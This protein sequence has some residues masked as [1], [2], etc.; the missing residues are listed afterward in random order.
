MK[1]AVVGAHL[2][3]LPLHSQL[4]DRGAAFVIKT[5][6]KPIY[7]FFALPGTTPPKPGLLRVIE[8]QANGIEVEIYDLS[9]ESFGDFV[10]LVPP[11]LSIGTVELEDGTAVKGFLVEAYAVAGAAE[12]THL[13]SWRAYL[14][15]L[16]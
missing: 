8:P 5:R 3:G 2:H 12:I 10:G 13:G 16:K 4:T 6:T 9:I 1:I 15:S 7:R 11:P 14:A